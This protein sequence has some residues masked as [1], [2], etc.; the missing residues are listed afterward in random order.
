MC[1]IPIQM[2]NERLSDHAQGAHYCAEN[3][4]K[5][6]SHTG[7]DPHEC[8]SVI[9]TGSVTEVGKAIDS[10]RCRLDTS[11]QLRV[12][13]SEL[14]STSICSLCRSVNWT[15]AG[16]QILLPEQCLRS[17][18]LAD[19]AQACKAVCTLCDLLD[20]TSATLVSKNEQSLRSCV[21]TDYFHRDTTTKLGSTRPRDR[22]PLEYPTI[23]VPDDA[24]MKPL[25]VLGVLYPNRPQQTYAPRLISSL[26]VDYNLVRSWLEECSEHYLKECSVIRSKNLWGFS[27]IHCRSQKVVPAPPGCSYVALSY[28]W[29][30]SQE[31]VR[32]GDDEIFPRTVSDSMTVTLALGFEYLCKYIL[33]LSLT[34]FRRS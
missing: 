13:I 19:N 9:V 20:H 11:Q 2:T 22:I 28:V 3:D 17:S 34:S 12:Y 33:P 7:H 16:Q 5:D 23:L 27:L 30:D 25:T 18:R 15:E 29:G 21:A 32:L 24:P 31:P 26:K 6:S 10:L 4:D 1:Y 8:S 14:D